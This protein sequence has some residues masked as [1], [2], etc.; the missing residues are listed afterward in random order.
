MNF[1]LQKLVSAIADAPATVE[2][3]KLYRTLGGS[4]QQLHGLAL[5]IP[6]AFPKTT[7]AGSP[8]FTIGWP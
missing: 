6:A 1:N 3:G 4:A 5:L 2:T 8:R 7:M